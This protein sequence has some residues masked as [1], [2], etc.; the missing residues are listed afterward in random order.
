RWSAWSSSLASC[1]VGRRT[2]GRLVRV[3]DRNPGAFENGGDEVGLGECADKGGLAIDD[4]VRNTPDTELVRQ[5]WELVRLNA[6]RLHLRRCQRHPVGQAH[7][8]GT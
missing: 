5:I 4:G 6:N 3:L 8:P 7:G 2:S 1:D